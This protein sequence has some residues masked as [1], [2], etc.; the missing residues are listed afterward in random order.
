MFAN[1]CP[2]RIAFTVVCLLSADR[3]VAALPPGEPVLALRGHEAGVFHVTYSP[4]GKTLA[5]SSK[6]NTA[7]LWDAATGKLL[8]TLRG[9]TKDVYSSAFS[10][11]GK[12]LAT[13]SGDHHMKLW[14]TATGKEVREFLGHGDDVYCVRFSPDGTRLASGGADRNVFVWDVATGNRL[15]ALP[16]HSG[17][18]LCVAFSP[19]GGRLVSACA[20]NASNAS[21]AAGEVRICDAATGREIYTLP[22]RNIGIV[23]VAFSPDGKRLAGSSL[24][25]G[26]KVWELATAQESLVLTGHTLEVYHVNFSP[27]G[28]RLASCSGKWSSDQGGELKIWDVATGTELLSFKP[29]TTPIWGS[30][31]SPDGKRLATASGKFNPRDGS[32]VKVWDVSGLRTPPAA[33]AP[34]VQRLETLWNELGAKDALKAYRAVFALS[35]APGKSVPFVTE[36]VRPPVSN[37]VYEC[38]PKLIADLDADD[39]EVRERAMKELEKIGQAAHPALLKALTDGSAEVKRLAELLLERKGEAP[40]LSVEEIHMLRAI[41]VLQNVGTADVRPALEKLAAGAAEAPV[42]R[43]ALLALQRL[44]GKAK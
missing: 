10:P 4:D 38:I 34:D 12:Y 18:V 1:R 17:R 8:F 5:T 32:E 3:V 39:F 11:D 14:D 36:R 7:R 30:S 23:T 35:A 16:S 40:P 22:S 42:T 28:R 15:H 20:S 33:A 44:D 19:D 6:D 24:K 43:D 41:E 26:V 29:H 31:F 25:H 9:H 2:C 13:V 27:D 37:S 21:E